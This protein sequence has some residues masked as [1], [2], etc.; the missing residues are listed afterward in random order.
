MNSLD[1]MKK[2]IKIS[3]MLAEGVH[4]QRKEPWE[5]V[6]ELIQA[7]VN[8]HAITGEKLVPYKGRTI[9]VWMEGSSN[10]PYKETFKIDPGKNTGV[11]SIDGYDY[12]ADEYVTHNSAD[13][14]MWS[15]QAVAEEYANLVEKMREVEDGDDWS[16]HTE[17]VHEQY[18]ETEVDSKKNRDGLP[19]GDFEVGDL[20]RIVG[21]SWDSLEDELEEYQSRKYQGKVGRVKFPKGQKGRRRGVLVVFGLNS[22]IA[23]PEDLELVK[24][25]HAE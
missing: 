20:V 14:Y 15:N 25:A 4:E 7:H 16:G 9:T 10:W 24:K 17:G 12:G 2:Y 11:I 18:D 1:S 21:N 6:D 8:Q 19:V 5:K 13:D 22:I 3:K 23:N